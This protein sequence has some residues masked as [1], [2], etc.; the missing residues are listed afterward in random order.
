[1]NEQ[2]CL[3]FWYTLAQVINSKI[4]LKVLRKAFFSL[5]N[6]FILNIKIPV[7]VIYPK[8]TYCLQIWPQETDICKTSCL[9]PFLACLKL[10]RGLV[11]LL[12][13]KTAPSP[14]TCGTNKHLKQETYAAVHWHSASQMRDMTLFSFKHSCGGEWKYR[15]QNNTRNILTRADEDREASKNERGEKQQEGEW[16]RVTFRIVFMCGW[17]HY[18]KRLGKPQH[19]SPG[20]KETERRCHHGYLGSK[21]LTYGEGYLR[22]SN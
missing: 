14:F 9:F 16:V 19:S 17:G 7:P 12:R 4:V 3:T 5:F 8:T 18:P 15:P 21:V 10:K 13:P 22:Q 2:Q 20:L 11:G 6:L 1:M